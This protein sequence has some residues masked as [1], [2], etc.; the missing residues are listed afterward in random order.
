LYKGYV[1][2]VNYINAQMQKENNSFVLQSLR[3][4]YA[5]EY[6]GMVLHEIYFC[7]LGGGGKPRNEYR[8]IEKIKSEFGSF[9]AFK[10]KVHSF[11][12]TRGIGW[13]ILFSKIDGGDLKLCWVQSHQDGF[14]SG[15]V[16][17]YVI[18]LW[19]HAYISQFGLD[20]QAY[21]D[22]MFEYTDW[23]IINY[24]YINNCKSIKS[25]FKK[26]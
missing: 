20:K 13:I 26:L 19:E 7:S 16:P 10:G 25:G 15:Y 23:K 14:L 5:F 21:I 2:Q 24:R 22:L 9:V 4:Q 3:K 12:K 1:A 6:D 17:V 8:I 18:D 11:A